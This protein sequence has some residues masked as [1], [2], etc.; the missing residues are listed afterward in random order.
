MAKGKR[1]IKDAQVV[2]NSDGTE[3]LVAPVVDKSGTTVGKD[4]L[5]HTPKKSFK[6][7]DGGV[8]SDVWHRLPLGDPATAKHNSQANRDARKRRK[9]TPKRLLK[10]RPWSGLRQPCRT[11]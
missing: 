9:K 6:G 4:V 11:K 7:K 8:Q 10:W 2:V 1:I 5:T 3:S